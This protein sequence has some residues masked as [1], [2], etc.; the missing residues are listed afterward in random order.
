MKAF[1]MK[2]PKC[3]RHFQVERTSDRVETKQGV[4]TEDGAAELMKGNIGPVYVPSSVDPIEES[5]EPVEVP[6]TRVTH[7]ETFTCKHCG[8]TWTEAH[9][10]VKS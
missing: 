6:V 4:V 8:Y 9:T 3:G 1:L 2:C 10:K 5:A 7:E